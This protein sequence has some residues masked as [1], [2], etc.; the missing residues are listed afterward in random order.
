MVAATAAEM[1]TDGGASALD[2]SLRPQVA[3]GHREKANSKNEKPKWAMGTRRLWETGHE[4]GTQQP[5][6]PRSARGL[7]PSLAATQNIIVENKQRARHSSANASV[8]RR[9]RPSARI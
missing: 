9:Q 7:L 8:N 3:M 4:R 5:T 1:H 6:I 2:D